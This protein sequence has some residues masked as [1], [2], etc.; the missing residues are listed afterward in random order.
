MR[1][2]QTGFTLIELLVVIAIIAILSAILFP[3]FAR[4]RENARRTSCSSNLRQIGLAAMQYVQDYDERY[5]LINYPSSQAPDAPRELWSI[6]GGSNQWLWPAQIYPYIKSAQVF[7]CPSSSYEPNPI[8][9]H[10]GANWPYVIANSPPA[11]SLAAVVAPASTYMVL[12]AGSYVVSYT[13]IYSPTANYIYTPGTAAFATTS[14]T[15]NAA[16]HDDWRNGR[17]FGGINIAFAD[18]HAKWVKSTVAGKEALEAR[19]G[20]PSAWLPTNPTY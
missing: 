10:Y 6:S 8:T 3:V 17:H 7:R 19:D 1:N 15:P 4:A 18:G 5:P 2:R 9:M 11:L 13:R 14:T 16:T 20:R 12:D